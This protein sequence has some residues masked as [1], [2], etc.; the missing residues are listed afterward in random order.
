MRLRCRLNR[1]R[2]AG[3]HTVTVRGIDAM[4]R[5]DEAAHGKREA[6]VKGQDP[7]IRV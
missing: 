4:A 2:G 1:P 7:V 5:P 3:E 6:V